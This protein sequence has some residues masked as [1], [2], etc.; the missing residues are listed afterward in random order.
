MADLLTLG[1]QPLDALLRPEISARLEAVASRVR[2]RDG[3]LI[4]A[5]GDNKP[6]FSIVAEGAVR[7][8]KPLVDG[9]ELTISLL[10]PGHF[11]GEATVF[12]DTGRAYDAI[13]VG[14]T[15]VDQISK[16]A[17]ER[18]LE[19]EP[20]LSRALLAATTRR[21]YAALSF[22]DDL[23]SLPLEARAAKLVLGMAASAKNPACVACRQS[24]LAFTLG[25][26][27]VSVG[28]ALGALQERGLIDLGYGEIRLPDRTALAR[29][30]AAY[31]A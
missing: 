5:R 13:A 28:K 27:R 6:G 1:D 12:A 8:V 14:E 16:T 30:I 26:S 22:L 25:V 11:F 31:E 7:F 10:G 15:A 19:K 24:D 17:F 3:R 29:W 4:H 23:R 18:L 20:A 2:Y 21:L 9:G